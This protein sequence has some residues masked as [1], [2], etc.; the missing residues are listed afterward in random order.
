[1]SYHFMTALVMRN[2]TM[3]FVVTILPVYSLFGQDS[4]SIIAPDKNTE[5]FVSYTNRVD[6]VLEIYKNHPYTIYYDNLIVEY[7]ERM[8]ANVHK[9]KVMARKMKKPQYSDP[10][11]FGHKRKPKKRAVGKRKFCKECEIVH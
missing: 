1:M 7:E 4:R 6:A 11:Y 3:L 8:K 10:S 5:S 9:Y 2:I